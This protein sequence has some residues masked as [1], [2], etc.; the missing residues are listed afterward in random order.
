M[1][2]NLW[3]F[4]LLLAACL[5]VSQGCGGGMQAIEKLPPPPPILPADASGTYMFTLDG[6]PGSIGTGGNTN[7]GI[8]MAMNL[9][10]GAWQSGTAQ[11]T[12][13]GQVND[14]CWTS[15]NPQPSTLNF[16]SSVTQTG[17]AKESFT[18]SLTNGDTNASILTMASPD[19]STL[20]GTWAPGPG[21]SWCTLS[22][23]NGGNWKA[24]KQ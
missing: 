1:I 2:R 7:G 6:Y 14:L 8:V 23:T 4:A 15:I 9:K 12:G 10:Q 21:I 22:G 13:T 19:F 3:I 20:S 24:V 5:T 17:N 18:F 11:L 16:T